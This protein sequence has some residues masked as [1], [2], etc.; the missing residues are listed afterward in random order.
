MARLGLVAATFSGL[1]FAE[2]QALAREAEAA[3]FEALYLP[4]FMND[5]LANCHLVTQATTRLKAATWVANIYLRHPVL[6]AQT[7]VAIDY[8]SQGRL[9]LGLGVSHRPIVEG[10][11]QAKMERPRD[12]LRHYVTTV[13]QVITGQGYPG[14]P[15]P[16]QSAAY[17]VPIYIAA[18]ALGTVEMAGELADGVMLDLCPQSRLP[19][20]RAALDRGAAKVGRNAAAVD[21]TLGLLACISD[22]VPA[23]KAA[24]KT[25]LAVYGAMPF[26]HRLF[27][28]SGFAQEAAAVVN[29]GAQ[30]ISD[31]MVEELVLY[32]PP[33]H[34]REQLAAYRAVGIQLP[35]IR[36]VAVGNQPYAQAVRRAIETFT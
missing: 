21:L 14:A 9:I 26:Y 30:A 3:G 32:G 1:S 34:C 24:A 18:L 17:G 2:L 6:C 5:A 13:R 27:Q 35:I 7:A 15:A 23:A 4:E 36:P 31:R 16:L 22:D 12:T 28:Q 19:K 11:Y 29:G 8:L 20:I 10:V 33:A 25:T